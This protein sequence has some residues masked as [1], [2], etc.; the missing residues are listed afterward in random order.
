MG[1]AK[2]PL[3]NVR[4]AD[5]DR[6]V[7]VGYPAG[8]LRI[9]NTP[10]GYPWTWIHVDLQGDSFFYL[11]LLHHGSSPPVRSATVLYAVPASQPTNQP[12]HTTPV[13]GDPS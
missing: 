6:G 11:Y 10:G 3:E 12:G 13:V 8:V 7:V 2:L 1:Q 5:G 9:K 4:R